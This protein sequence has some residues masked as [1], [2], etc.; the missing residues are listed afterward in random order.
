[1]SNRGDS[2]DKVSGDMVKHFLLRDGA[3]VI[4]CVFIE[5]AEERLLVDDVPETSSISSKPTYSWLTAWL[6][7]CRP[8]CRRKVPAPLIFRNSKWRAYSG[9]SM[10]SGFRAVEAAA[11]VPTSCRS[12]ERIRS[13]SRSSA[14]AARS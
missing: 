14:E 2:C 8:Q 5:A 11:D 3:P 4:V 10:R 6:R 13:F 12:R 7:K 9:G 1:M